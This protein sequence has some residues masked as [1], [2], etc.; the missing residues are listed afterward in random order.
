MLRPVYYIIDECA[1]LSADGSKYAH[2]GNF[3][4]V[5]TVNGGTYTNRR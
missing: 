1:H 2:D 5:S 3:P 4:V